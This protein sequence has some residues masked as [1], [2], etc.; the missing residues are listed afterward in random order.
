MDEQSKS[1][2]I[3]CGRRV[4][5]FKVSV[6]ND[7]KDELLLTLSMRSS[8][9]FLLLVKQSSCRLSS[10]PRKSRLKMNEMYLLDND[11][12][13]LRTYRTAASSFGVLNT[14]KPPNLHSPLV[15]KK[16]EPIRTL[17]CVEFPG[18]L[19]NARAV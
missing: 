6:D 16:T 18:S 3:C 8:H 13:D 19:T 12:G 7:E 11:G 4:S 5:A 10:A 15:D 2:A 14:S 17:P 9:S 1:V